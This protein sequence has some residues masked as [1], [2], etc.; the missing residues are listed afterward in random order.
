MAIIYVAIDGDDIGRMVGHAA[1]SNDEEFLSKI[2]AAINE[3]REDVQHLA[4]I[5]GG[6]VISSGGDEIVVK[7]YGEDEEKLLQ[8][9]H[10]MIQKVADHSEEYYGFT[11]TAGLGNRLDHALK[12]LMA[13]KLSGKNQVVEYTKG[14]DHLIEGIKSGKI[15]PKHRELDEKEFQKLYDEYIKFLNEKEKPKEPEYEMVDGRIIIDEHPIFEKKDEHFKKFLENKADQDDSESDEEKDLESQ[16]SLGSEE[17]DVEEQ[18][19]EW[20]GFEPSRE[21]EANEGLETENIERAN[22][23]GSGNTESNQG[24]A[25]EDSAGI[26]SGGSEQDVAGTVNEEERQL[27]SAEEQEHDP[28]F[29]ALI[30]E[31]HEYIKIFKS[32]ASELENL[33]E[34]DPELYEAMLGMLSS[35]IDTIRRAKGIPESEEGDEEL[36]RSQEQ[37]EP[38]SLTGAASPKPQGRS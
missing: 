15:P 24:N 4:E 3:A 12:A 7:F 11:I 29:D 1:L 13:G 36:D 9:V 22:K 33:R 21:E 17:K 28:E 14:V 27:E 5:H 26:E 38:G 35:L 25:E 10:E 23:T 6:E 16:I 8:D 19:N 37:D 2:S 34:T 31:I 30:A 20:Q 18:D 32:R